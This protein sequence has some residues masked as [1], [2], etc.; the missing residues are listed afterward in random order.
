MISQANS[1]Q[2][3]WLP[4]GGAG[5]LDGTSEPA[6]LTEGVWLVEW[7][8]LKNTDDTPFAAI[9]ALPPE[10]AARK[11]PLKGE[12]AAPTGLTCAPAGTMQASN[13]RQAALSESQRGCAA[14]THSL[15][16]SRANTYK[17]HLA[18]LLGELSS[19]AR[20]RGAA[21]TRGFLKG[22]ANSYQPFFSAT[23]RTLQKGA[24]AVALSVSPYGLPAPPMGE[25]RK[26]LRIRL[27]AFQMV[28]CVPRLT[29]PARCAASP[30]RG[31]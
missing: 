1:Q 23:R 21:G 19:K 28:F 18:P 16:K 6:R 15:I 30:E 31:G 17:P 13:R 9:A 8:Q 27:G 2:P 12:L 25:P 4:N 29:P 24:G 10:G 14:G 26:P 7:K 5:R 22:Q 20:L 3:T 11:A